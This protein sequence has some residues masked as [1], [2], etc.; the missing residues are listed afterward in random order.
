MAA[1]PRE[2]LMVAGLALVG[3]LGGAA[4]AAA[5]S[6]DLRTTDAGLTPLSITGSNAWTWVAGTG[7]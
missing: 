5:Q 1:R 6:F 7:G 2:F 3:G 4:P